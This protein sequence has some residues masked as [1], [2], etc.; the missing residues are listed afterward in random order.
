MYFLGK[1]SN[2]IST[3]AFLNYAN[4][5]FLSSPFL[6]TGLACLYASKSFR[7]YQTQIAQRECSTCMLEET[8]D[9]PTFPK[10]V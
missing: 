4:Y 6:A 2:L 10:A 9:L 1:I 7:F 5:L 3:F 8:F